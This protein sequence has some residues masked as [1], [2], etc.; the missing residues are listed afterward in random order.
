[1]NKEK[2]SSQDI[3]DLL[4]SK[5]SVSKRASEE[6]LKVLIASIEDALLAG[7][8]VKIK[9]FGT[10]KLH[11]NE[12]RKSV[13]VQ[14]GAEIILA[15]Y[16]K[17][18]F[19]PDTTL[20]D[21]INEPFAHLEAVE[22][23]TDNN[24]IATG[25]NENAMVDPLRIFTEQAS[26]IKNLL[27][28]IQALSPTKKVNISEKEAERPI[29]VDLK[30]ADNVVQEEIKIEEQKQVENKNELESD[31]ETEVLSDYKVSPTQTETQ[32]EINSTSET[33]SEEKFSGKRRWRLL[34]IIILFL[35]I[36]GGT[37]LYFFYQPANEIMKATIDTCKI[38]FKNFEDN[39]SFSEMLNNL[40]KW[41]TPKP[42]A[43]PATE[44]VVIPK[45]T[46]T[47]AL[48]AVE[49]TVDSLQILFDTPRVYP[50]FI[51][52]ER[53]KIGSR[54]ALMAK[55]YYGTSDFW[56]YIYEANKDRIQN[57]DNIAVGT[58][59][60]IPKLDSRLIDATNPRCIKKALELHDLYVKPTKLGL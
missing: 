34:T 41:V 25:N 60:H 4:A 30:P 52:S 31:K 15:G 45:E 5:A 3:I 42:K 37:G 46:D 36:S 20:K 26:E 32:I 27:S 18:I 38:G 19:A 9:N 57:P 2:I 11:W 55:R 54:L 49:Q 40:T 24:E 21:V 7:D 58:L 59:I 50:V 53:I 44:T 17:V 1:M 56:V 22:L 16:H 29:Q 13:N 8:T 43:T 10:F 28:E 12:P 14:T 23:D 6:F 35:F 47:T 48:K 51:A 39:A 33:L